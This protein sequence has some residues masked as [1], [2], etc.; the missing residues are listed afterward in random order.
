MLLVVKGIMNVILYRKLL[1]KLKVILEESYIFKK[2][3]DQ[4]IFSCRLRI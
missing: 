2:K 3:L 4:C 1:F